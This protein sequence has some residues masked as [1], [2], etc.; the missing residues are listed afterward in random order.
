MSIP[1]L[2]RNLSAAH[3]PNIHTEP[4]ARVLAEKAEFEGFLALTLG[5][6]TAHYL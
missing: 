6:F 2:F 3:L 1:I 4:V 5:D